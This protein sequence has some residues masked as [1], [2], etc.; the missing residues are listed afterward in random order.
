MFEGAF[1][2]SIS[3]A[4]AF[5][6]VPKYHTITPGSVGSQETKREELQ[7]SKKSQKLLHMCF[8]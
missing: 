1:H 3:L 4:S 6:Q 5:M 8:P 2:I 7:S